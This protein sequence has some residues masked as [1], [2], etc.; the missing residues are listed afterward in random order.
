MKQKI[1]THIRQQR[2]NISPRVYEHKSRVITQTLENRPIFHHAKKIMAYLSNSEEVHTHQLIL[3]CLEKGREIFVP[4][5]IGDR[6]AICRLHDWKD[7]RKG[8]FGILEPCRMLDHYHPAEM[9][10]IIVPGIAFDKKGHRIG[11]G[12]GFYDKLLKDTSGYKIGLAFEEQIVESIPAE[13]HDIP[14]DLIISDKHIYNP[15]TL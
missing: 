14:L 2:L 5:V 4:K 10:L 8:E 9:D 12:K 11:Y 15:K 13:A 7:L 3:D 1:R 6:L